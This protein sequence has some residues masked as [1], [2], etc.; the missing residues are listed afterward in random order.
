[1]QPFVNPRPSLNGKKFILS[2]P[3]AF[4]EWVSP[5]YAAKWVEEYIK[6]NGVT[7]SMISNVTSPSEYCDESAYRNETSWGCMKDEQ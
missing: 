2:I 5:S 6:T 1:M 7:P 3:F 4:D